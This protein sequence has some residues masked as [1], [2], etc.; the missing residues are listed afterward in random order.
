MALVAIVCVALSSCDTAP[1]PPPSEIM[2]DDGF[3]PYVDEH[4]NISFPEGFRTSMVHLGS[5]F[6]P[7]G[8]ASGFHD[9]YTEKAT[10]EEAGT[11]RFPIGSRTGGMLPVVT[12]S[13]KIWRT[14]MKPL[15]SSTSSAAR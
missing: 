8:V 2:A 9:V 11:I 5:W 6:V 14:V 13:S 15:E 4:G 10:V 7:E 1:P 3:S 12:A